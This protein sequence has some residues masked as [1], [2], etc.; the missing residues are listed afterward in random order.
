MTTQPNIYVNAK[1]QKFLTVD[2]SRLDFYINTFNNAAPDLYG[3]HISDYHGYKL[4]NIDFLRELNDVKKV[5]IQSS[6][7]NMSGLDDL[8]TLEY[9]ALNEAT[10][11]VI[12]ILSYP[13][14]KKF[15]GVWSNKIKNLEQAHQLRG[16]G[17]SNF[18]PKSGSLDELAGLTNL[19][20]LHLLQCSMLTLSGIEHFTSLK[21]LYVGY[22]RNLKDISAINSDL[23]QVTDIHFQNCKKVESFAGLAMLPSLNRISLESC[24]DIDSISFVRDMS[25]LEKLFFV[26][27]H[28]LDGDLSPC[29]DNQMLKLVGFKNKKHY[30]HKE[31]DVDAILF[32]RQNQ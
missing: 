10:S 2:S 1:K 28:V 26:D 7:K 29:V 18:K 5:F 19:V 14:M 25:K 8:T 21:D 32:A 22:M 15:A 4:D 17:L 6:I 23:A 30:S 31:A 3:I 13:K 9:L 12:D 24:G 11:Q 20:D 16:L 27:T